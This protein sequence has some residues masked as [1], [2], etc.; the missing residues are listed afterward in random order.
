MIPCSKKKWVIIGLQCCSYCHWPSDF[1]SELQSTK[2]TFHHKLRT[3]EGRAFGQWMKSSVM[4][5]FVHFIY[6]K[7]HPKSCH[8]GTNYHVTLNTLFSAP[9]HDGANQP[10]HWFL[11]GKG[12]GIQLGTSVWVG[13]LKSHC[14]L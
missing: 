11:G 7:R 13:S 2:T 4:T 14:M 3:R 10:I 1:S 6:K 9:L 12:L 5:I 8:S